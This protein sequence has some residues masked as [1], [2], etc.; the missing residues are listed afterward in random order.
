MS[1]Q[2]I[3]RCGSEA[4]A[5][6]VVKTTLFQSM[7][8]N[9]FYEIAANLRYVAI[10]RTQIERALFQLE[11]EGDI[12]RMTAGDGRHIWRVKL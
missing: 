7:R 8:W 11:A 6:R 12:E 1:T 10:T 5:R 9:F 3:Y 2:T 4:D